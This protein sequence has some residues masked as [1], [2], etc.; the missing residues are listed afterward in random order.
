M[1]VGLTISKGQFCQQLTERRLTE[2]YKP[3]LDRRL[4]FVF[5]YTSLTGLWK[6]SVLFNKIIPLIL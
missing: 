3:T 2:Q 6:N 5:L 1:Y 4:T